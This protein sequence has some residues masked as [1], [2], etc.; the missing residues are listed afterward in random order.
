MRTPIVLIGCSASKTVGTNKARHL[1]TGALFRLC[2]RWAEAQGYSWLVL[3]A[4]HGVVG[5]DDVIQAY[6]TRLP[7]CGEDRKA[8]ATEAFRKLKRRGALERPIIILAGERY[9]EYLA[10]RLRAESPY[11]VT[12]PLRSLGIGHQKQRLRIALETGAPLSGEKP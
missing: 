12:H 9:R 6:D 2:V 4:L 7:A 1:Y 5:P 11:P 8:W 3:S 10:P